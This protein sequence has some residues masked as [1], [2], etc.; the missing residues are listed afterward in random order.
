MKKSESMK[1]KFLY[2][3]VI[4]ACCLPLSLLAGFSLT[5]SN[6][7]SD[8]FCIVAYHVIY[9]Y[10]DNDPPYGCSGSFDQDVATAGG[11]S[12]TRIFTPN[13]DCTGNNVV[14]A[15]V[16]ISGVSVDNYHTWDYSDKGSV[17]VAVSG[18]A[19]QANCGGF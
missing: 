8:P 5:L 10:N 19:I 1:S 6:P 17:Y 14:S 12:Y 18:A 7:S 13:G 2:S 9:Y 4:A 15:L 11:G 3:L 16:K